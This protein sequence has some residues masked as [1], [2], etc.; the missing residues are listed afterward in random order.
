MPIETKTPHRYFQRIAQA[1]LEN[2]SDLQTGQLSRFLLNI[3]SS[4]AIE[5]AI[6]ASD[7]QIGQLKDRALWHT[8]QTLPLSG[9]PTEKLQASINASNGYT[10]TILQNELNPFID[11]AREVVTSSLS[12]IQSSSLG[13]EYF[14]D[15]LRS[16]IENQLTDKFGGMATIDIAIWPRMTTGDIRLRLNTGMYRTKDRHVDQENRVN[17]TTRIPT[18]IEFLASGL[19]G[20]TITP[21]RSYYIRTPEI[22]INQKDGD[23]NLKIEVDDD[24]PSFIRQMKQNKLGSQSLSHNLDGLTNEKLISKVTYEVNKGKKENEILILE[25]PL[26]SIKAGKESTAD[27]GYIVITSTGISF[28]ISE[29]AQIL[30]PSAQLKE[31]QD[32]FSQIFPR[33][34]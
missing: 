34:S 28:K 8:L 26:T 27:H 4:I 33:N 5:E 29:L 30:S 22:T 10:T 25:I 13:H 20:K 9:F 16:R 17:I 15:W 3:A 6:N 2:I 12:S 32:K 11:Q 7:K 31:L 23:I 21:K 18:P 1:S 19:L 14:P 24:A